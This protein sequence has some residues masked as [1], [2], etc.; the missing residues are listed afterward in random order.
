MQSFHPSYAQ[1]CACSADESERPDLWHGLLSA[2]VPRLGY[3]GGIVRDIGRGRNDGTLTNMEIAT[4]WAMT[5]DGL[6]LEFGGTDEYVAAGTTIPDLTKPWTLAGR[7][8]LAASPDDG[9][10]WPFGGFHK[11]DAEWLTLGINNV[12]GTL[13][14]KLGSNGETPGNGNAVLS[15][16]VT[17]HLTIT[18]DGSDLHAYIDGVLDY[19][20]TPTASDWQT[21]TTIILAT[22]SPGAD[23]RH[24]LN[25]KLWDMLIYDR[26]VTVREMLDLTYDPMAMFRPRRRRVVRVPF[27]PYPRPRGLRA[28]MGELV[29]GRH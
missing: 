24:F 6:A 2:F 26:A 14:T 17:Y 11:D 8:H 4:D 10:T 29:G 12:G 28:G 3:T 27:I 19:S 25:G 13:L 21:S 9:F 22:H 15:T 20:V 7:I 1:G 23:A 5:K 18:H 16:G